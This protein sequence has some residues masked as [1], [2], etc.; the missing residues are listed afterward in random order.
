[1]AKITRLLVVYEEDP[2]GGSEP[3]FINLAAM[4]L[5]VRP[6][7]LAEILDDLAFACRDVL[8]RNNGPAHALASLRMIK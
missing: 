3:R 4:Q 7:R 6:E 2:A 8:A 5:A 1:M